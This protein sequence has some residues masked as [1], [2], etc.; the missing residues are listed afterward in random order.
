M[1]FCRRNPLL[2][3]LLMLLGFKV[4]KREKYT[5]EDKESYRAK[6]REFR[7]KIRE[8]FDVWDHADPASDAPDAAA[9][10]ER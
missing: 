3:M 4:L 2:K 5:T 7:H 10:L 6:R 8:A 1:F 9:P